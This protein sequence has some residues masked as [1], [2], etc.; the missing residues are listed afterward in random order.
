[1][2]WHLPYQSV[3]IK[4]HPRSEGQNSSKI[5]IVDPVDIQILILPEAFKSC[6]LIRKMPGKQGYSP[7]DTKG[8]DEGCTQHQTFV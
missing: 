8:P 1:M 6:G 2:L 3:L 5:A 4:T 7:S